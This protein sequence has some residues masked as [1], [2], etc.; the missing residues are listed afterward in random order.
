MAEEGKDTVCKAYE[1][2]DNL[3][4]EPWESI[5][6]ARKKKDMETLL[7]MQLWQYLEKASLRTLKN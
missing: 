1:E 3:A 2:A 7:L 6:K 5:K 4:K